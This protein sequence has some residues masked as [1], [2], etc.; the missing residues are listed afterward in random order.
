MSLKE[1]MM[2]SMMGNM[3]AEE[4]KEMMDKMM[5]KFFAD[6]T[7]EEKQKLMQDM[8]T[9]MM[10]NFMGKGSNSAEDGSGGG[11][12]PMMDMMK[13]MMGGKS[14]M[15][16][17]MMGKG[18]QSEGKDEKPWDMCQKMMS[19]ISKSSDL[20]TFATPEVRSLFEEW[21][22]Q[23]EEEFLEFIK[24]S[25]SDKIEQLQDQFKLSKESVNYFLARLAQKGKIKFKIEKEPV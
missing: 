5:D 14:S 8:M 23:I 9:K 13:M 25:G 6:M 19:S 12:F 10:G 3:S 24:T 7:P 4:K 1:K 2:D 21:V 18:M 20:A 15:M 22:Q 11:I 17:M 16:S